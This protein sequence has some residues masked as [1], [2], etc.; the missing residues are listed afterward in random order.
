MT[1]AVE[2]ALIDWL[3]GV[4]RRFQQYFSHITATAHIIHAFLGLTSTRLGSEV[5]CP[6]TLPRKD[7]EDPV[8]L[9]PRSPGLRVKHFTTEPRGTLKVALNPNTTNQPTLPIYKIYL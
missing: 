2:V 1:L 4:L 5:S 9:E 7:P 6:S 3:N 8:R